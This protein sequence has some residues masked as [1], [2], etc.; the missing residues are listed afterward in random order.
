V[1]SRDLSRGQTWEHTP[2]AENVTYGDTSAC[3]LNARVL[4][5]L[6]ESQVYR[7]DH[8]LA[9]RGSNAPSILSFCSM[10]A[11][12]IPIDYLETDIRQMPTSFE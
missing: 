2:A 7:M 6:S 11:V 3:E 12:L 1:P 10:A 5:V 4:K 8:F 9:S